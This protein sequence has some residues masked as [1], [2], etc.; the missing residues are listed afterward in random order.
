MARAA[1][2]VMLEHGLNGTTLQRVADHVGVSKASVL[3]YFENKNI[4][5]ETAL[6]RANAALR[7]EAVSLLK[8][9]ETPWERFYAVVEANFSPTTFLPKVAHSWVAM[10]AEVPHNRQFHRL[11]NAIYRRLNSNLVTALIPVSSSREEAALA[12]EMVSILIDGLWMRCGCEIGGLERKEAKD[13]IE[14]FL[15]SRYGK[16]KQRLAARDKMTMLAT[17]VCAGRGLI[18][19]R[20]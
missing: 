14:T 12:A 20:S 15:D 6:R 16:S 8:L 17:A 7:S 4:L 11:Q 10:C 3:H 18:P 5:I 13:R 2:E 9:A 1:F 19:H